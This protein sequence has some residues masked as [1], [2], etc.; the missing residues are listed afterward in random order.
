MRVK[1]YVLDANIWLSYFITQR[2]HHLAAI[3]LENELTLFYCDE[4]IDELKRVCSY[5]H[6]QKYNID[7]NKIFRFV[8]IAAVHFSLT[9]PIIWKPVD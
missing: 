7:S 4:L 1:K 2:E 6:I 3:I 9:Y 8:Q 5:K